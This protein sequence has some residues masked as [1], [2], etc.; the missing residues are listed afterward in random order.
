MKGGLLIYRCRNCGGEEKCV[1]VPDTL[2][3][4]VSLSV[5]GKTP[6]KWGI[7]VSLTTVHNCPD[8]DG[9]KRLGLADCI[10]CEED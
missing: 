7:T 10:G 4:L 3:S 8:K 5:T 1:H 2:A 6:S 9:K